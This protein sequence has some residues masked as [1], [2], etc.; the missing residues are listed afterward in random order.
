MTAVGCV[1]RIRRRRD[2]LLVE[3]EVP[4][5]LHDDLDRWRPLL[6][7]L[8]RGDQFGLR[9]SRTLKPD[10]QEPCVVWAALATG[11]PA[12]S[13]QVIYEPRRR[14]APRRPAPSASDTSPY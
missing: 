5:E 2:Y 6:A 14:R 10:G 13:R 7:A 4:D 11:Q 1:P 3:T 8:E 9:A 12:R